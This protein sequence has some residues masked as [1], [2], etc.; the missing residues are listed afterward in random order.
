MADLLA[1]FCASFFASSI[2]MSV[3]TA[4]LIKPKHTVSATEKIAC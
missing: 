2:K 1:I 4:R 3:G